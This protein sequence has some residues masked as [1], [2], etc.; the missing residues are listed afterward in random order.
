MILNTSPKL[1]W[2]LFDDCYADEDSP[3]VEME[4]NKGYGEKEMEMLEENARNSEIK[5]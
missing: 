4:M 2:D 1:L 5:K 3:T